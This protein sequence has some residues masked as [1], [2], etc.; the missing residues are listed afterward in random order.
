V[1]TTISADDIQNAIRR[2][3][4]L[5]MFSDIQIILE[6]EVGTSVY[7]KI[8]VEELP[9]LEKVQLE[10]NKK[11]KKKDLEKEITFFPGMLVGPARR[12][13]CSRRLNQISCPQNRKKATGLS[14]ASKSV[15]AT[16]YRLRRSPF[17]EMSISATA[18]CASR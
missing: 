4:S 12:G 1:G 2:L 17:T 13:I 10:G 5:D 7:L 14:C 9:R 3:W 18:N 16:K 6:R 8:K 11:I 15:K